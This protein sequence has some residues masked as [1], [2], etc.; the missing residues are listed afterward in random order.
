MA[1]LPPSTISGVGLPEVPAAQDAAWITGPTGIAV[2]LHRR[3]AGG[4]FELTWGGLQV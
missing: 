2:C 4:V 1:A 3:L